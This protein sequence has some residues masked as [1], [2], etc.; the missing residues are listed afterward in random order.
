MLWETVHF[1]R[2][3][4]LAQADVSDAESIRNTEIL[5]KSL[6]SLGQK[7]SKEHA[8]YTLLILPKQ[9]KSFSYIL[10]NK[11]LTKKGHV[12]LEELSVS[13]PPLSSQCRHFSSF[14][15]WW[16]NFTSFSASLFPL[17]AKT[18]FTL[19]FLSPLSLSDPQAGPDGP[20]PHLPSQ[21]SLS[22]ALPG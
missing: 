4:E 3:G 12:W 11:G 21:A 6:G 1:A 2:R 20:G 10:N 14:F 8:N 5:L 9:V 18:L 13:L 17:H 16:Q 7:L 19:Q 22:G 15:S